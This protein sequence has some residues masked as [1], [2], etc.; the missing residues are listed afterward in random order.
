MLAVGDF[1]TISVI[2]GYGTDDGWKYADFSTGNH[3]T[4][5]YHFCLYTKDAV[6]YTH[7]TLPTTSR[8]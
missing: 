6:S 2:S 7:L 1:F 3:N 5:I 8:V 4:I